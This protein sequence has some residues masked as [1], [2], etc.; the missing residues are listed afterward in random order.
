MIDWEANVDPAFYAHR[1]MEPVRTTGSEEEGWYEEWICYKSEVAGAK[2]LT[3]LPG[4]EA[5]VRDPG[6]YGTICVEG[7]GKIGVHDLESPTLSRFGQLTRDEYFVTA[8]AA[9]EGVTVKNLS[10]TQPLVL[11]QH[12][13][14]TS[15]AAPLRK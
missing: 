11:L 6:A 12:M 3:V 5:T 4:G 7:F 13:A 1:F 2:R 10:R 8:E 14:N 9:K 15:E